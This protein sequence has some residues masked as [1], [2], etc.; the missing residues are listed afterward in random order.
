[1]DFMFTRTP[2]I[3]LTTF[4]PDNN[5]AAKGLGLKGG[6]RDWF[7][8][9]QH[10][11]GPGMQARIDIDDWICRTRDLEADGE[12]FHTALEEAKKASGSSLPVHGHDPIHER[13][14][15]AA[16]RMFTR[17]QAKKATSLYNRWAVN[18]GYAPIQLLS[19]EPTTVDVVDAVCRLVEGEMTIVE[20]REAA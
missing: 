10:P 13:Y 5:H 18:A 15:G 17:G 1:M 12:K 4:L 3:Q 8:R 6:F 14:V 7:R 9:E 11:C 19:E 16:Y 20:L 2:A